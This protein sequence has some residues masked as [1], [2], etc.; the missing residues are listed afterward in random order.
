M[1]KKVNVPG[2]NSKVNKISNR[3]DVYGIKLTKL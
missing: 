1:F 3:K 2:L